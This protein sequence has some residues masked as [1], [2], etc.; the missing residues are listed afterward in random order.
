MENQTSNITYQK[1]KYQE[2]PQVQ[3]VFK[4]RRYHENP[5]NKVNYQ[6]AKYQENPEKQ[7]E[8]K[9]GGT[10]KILYYH[11]NIKKEVLGKKVVARLRIS[12]NK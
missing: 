4:K 9:K 10:K 1:A 7:I 3:L 2:N 11:D 8:F 6:K 5:E 12:F